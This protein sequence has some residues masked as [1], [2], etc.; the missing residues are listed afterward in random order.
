VQ[1]YSEDVLSIDGGHRDAPRQQQQVSDGLL[2]NKPTPTILEK[3][4][5]DVLQKINQPVMTRT[6]GLTLSPTRH[7]QVRQQ[8]SAAGD[9]SQTSSSK[10]M[11]VRD[12]QHQQVSFANP[13]MLM[14]NTADILETME[15]Q[16]AN[17]AEEAD[18]EGPAPRWRG[19]KV[20]R[21]FDKKGKKAAAVSFYR[22]FSSRCKQLDLL[23]FLCNDAL[24]MLH[25]E[26]SLRRRA[27]ANGSNL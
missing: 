26:G 23:P 4:T 8:P 25:D 11:A 27:Y 12:Y 18:T 13:N 17:A 14:G 5:A 7:Q 19:S 16:T 9:L 2:S 15:A 20:V 24:F 1:G 6:A 10:A 22:Y 21:V 3:T